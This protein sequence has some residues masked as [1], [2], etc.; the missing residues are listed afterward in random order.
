[1][2]VTRSGDT[3]PYAA[4]LLLNSMPAVPTKLDPQATWETRFPTDADA[5]VEADKLGLQD[6]LLGRVSGAQGDSA[7]IEV[8]GQVRALRNQGSTLA[9]GGDLP[10]FE[11]LFQWNF[12]LTGSLEFATATKQV[13][14]AE[15]SYVLVPVPGL[16][17]EQLVK[18][19]AFQ[20]AV[21]VAQN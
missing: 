4:V 7:R 2:R 3:P 19:E 6:R 11:S 5:N 15:F 12:F 16:T 13:T 20:H 10:K 1:L 17:R 14:R 8:E 21:L 18:Q 9:L